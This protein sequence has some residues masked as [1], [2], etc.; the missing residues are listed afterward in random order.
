M[1]NRCTYSNLPSR[2]C[3]LERFCVNTGMFTFS[4]STCGGGGG[5]GVSVLR[6]T[7]S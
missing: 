7:N 5:G 6:L 3:V 4:R 2:Y 1:R